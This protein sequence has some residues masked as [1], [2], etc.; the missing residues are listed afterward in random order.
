MRLLQSLSCIVCLIWA[1]VASAQT[2]LPT[3]GAPRAV[4]IYGTE[5]ALLLSPH[6]FVLEDTRDTLT[7]DQIRTARNGWQQGRNDALVFGF[8]ESSWWVHFRVHNAALERV[9]STIDLGNPRQDYVTWNV[10]RDDGS[11]ETIESGDRLPFSTRVSP[12]RNLVL[13]LITAPDES[14]DLFVKLRSEDGLFEAMPLRLSR[15]N[16]FIKTTSREEILFTICAGGLLALGLYNLLLYFSTRERVF[17]IY[18]LYLALLTTWTFTFA[19]FAFQHIWPDQ[20][21]LNHVVLTLT[22][23]LG[24]AAF[25][26]F[27]LEYLRVRER[28]PRWLYR[29]HLSLIAYCTL[30]CIPGVFGSFALGAALAYAGGLAMSIVTIATAIYLALKGSREAKFFVI[31]F[32]LLWT[33]ICMYIL[34][35]V[36]I[37]PTNWFTTWSLQMGLS[38]ESLLLALGLADSLN[39]LKAEKFDAERRALE[40]QQALN[41]KLEHE[42]SERTKAL[43]LANRRLQE[44]TIT[45]ELTGAFNRRHFNA[46]CAATIANRKRDGALAFCMFDIDYFKA[47][48]D[49]YGHQAGDAAL[50]A[51]ARAVQAQLHRAGD[52]LFRLGGEEFGVAFDAGT[53][54]AAI[55]F[56][57]RLRASIRQ[58]EIV[59]LGSPYG[60]ITASFGV[61]W[62][63]SI[64]VHRLTAEQIYA[65][66]DRT[67]YV[68]KTAG[69]DRIEIA[70]SSPTGMYPTLNPDNPAPHAESA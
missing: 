60:I 1:A 27:A 12:R 47:Y 52:V 56:A 29:T 13:Q 36:A 31:A 67:L 26:W 25:G 48:N 35:I 21:N 9:I 69:R 18:V 16:V 62:W 28:V 54:Q 66:A 55:Q 20:V 43:E 45:D 51:V 22:S 3:D 53:Q 15:T 14:V 7:L 64:V 57:E 5:D 41:L 68:A 32:G 34:Q 17:G 10:V 6:S 44:L 23:A 70:S 37:V 4:D 39:V 24:I 63:S 58:L 42:V 46:I 65:V 49:R 61:G 30:V 11:V 38:L 40:A 2:V 59:H 8:S 19:G 50:R 33:G